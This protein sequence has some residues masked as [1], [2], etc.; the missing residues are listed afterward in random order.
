MSKKAPSR[1]SV[2]FGRLID[3]FGHTM[4]PLE[5]EMSKDPFSVNQ[6]ALFPML[7]LI[8]RCL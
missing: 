3:A 7:S 5:Y 1:F 4:N 6:F 8:C 2:D